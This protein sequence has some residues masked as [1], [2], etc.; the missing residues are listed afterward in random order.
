MLCTKKIP[1]LVPNSEPPVQQRVSVEG[2]LLQIHE[3]SA[4]SRGTSRTARSPP[5]LSVPM[6]HGPSPRLEDRGC[7]SVLSRASAPGLL[8]KGQAGIAQQGEV[9]QNRALTDKL[10]EGSTAHCR[11]GG[12]NPS[13]GWGPFTAHQPADPDKSSRRQG[14]LKPGMNDSKL[15]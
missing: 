10:N 6:T 11:A 13:H 2:I 4:C 8:R 9:S 15:K 5:A 12:G 3:A 7:A 14:K 1:R